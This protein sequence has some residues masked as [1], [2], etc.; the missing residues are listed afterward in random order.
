MLS[1]ARGFTFTT[2][3]LRALPPEIGRLTALMALGL[4]YNRLTAVPPEIGQLTALTELYL[5]GNQLTALPPE[6]GRLTGLA[7]LYLQDNRLTSLPPE[8]GRLTHL[9]RLY[10]H[11]NPLL[12]LPPEVLGPTSKD[13][14][15]KNAAPAPSYRTSWPSTS[16]GR[17]RP[18]TPWPVRWSR[19]APVR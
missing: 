1:I 11:G 2:T 10:L 16:A 13:V 3:S 12:G 5:C 7:K 8:L 17:R 14:G 6:I 15:N 19:Q 9:E 18:R 4:A